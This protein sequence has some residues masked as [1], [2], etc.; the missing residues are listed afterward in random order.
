MRILFLVIY[1]HLYGVQTNAQ[2]DFIQVQHSKVLGTLSFINAASGAPGSPPSYIDFI[3]KNLE[4]DPAFQELISIYKALDFETSMHREKF[5][6]KR[7]AYTSSMN[8][9]W[10]S[11]ANASSIDDFAIRSIGFLPPNDH[12]SFIKIMKQV[13][14]YYEKLVWSVTKTEREEME[15]GIKPY[16]VKIGQLFKKVNVFLGSEW[17]ESTPFKIMLYPIPLSQGGTTAIPMGNNLIC[18]YLSGRKEDPIGLV[19][20][21]VHEMDHILYDAQPLALQKA[22]DKWFTTSTNPFAPLAYDFFDEGL[23]TA[24]GNGWAYEEINGMIDTGEWYNFEYVNGFGKALFPLAKDYLNSGKTIDKA[25]IDQAITLF[26]EAFPKA[27]NDLDILMNNINVFSQS[28]DE[29]VINGYFDGIGARFRMR[30][31]Y[32]SSPMNKEK[33][34][35]RFRESN[36]TKMVLLDENKEEALIILQKQF[37]K[38]PKKFDLKKPQLTSF[39]DV[40]TKSN[41]ILLN[42]K[43]AQDYPALMDKLKSAKYLEHGKFLTI[44]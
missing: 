30:S 26:E 6:E 12:S 17:S 40:E 9:L 2:S 5:P 20:V 37:P 15:D 22:I 19:G 35:V 10:I 42:L 13:E 43:S 29:A 18:S 34:L 27:T 24:V 7:H 8:L 3:N 28:E 36:R 39:Y 44:D 32:F 16:K 14:P 23:A 4:N 31:V 21:A 38:F 25:F 11:S 33:S 1:F 41:V